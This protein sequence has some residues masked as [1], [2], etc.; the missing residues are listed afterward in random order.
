MPKAKKANPKVGGLFDEVAASPEEKIARL[1]A[2][3]AVRGL[4]SGDQIVLLRSV[5]FSTAEVAKLLFASENY[6]SVALHAAKK[7]LQK[8]QKPKYLKGLIDGEI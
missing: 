5:G 7:G 1:L 4:P 8:G 6:V 3:R 2:L